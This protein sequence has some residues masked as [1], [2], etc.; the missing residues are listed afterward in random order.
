M[1]AEAFVVGE[2]ESLASAERAAGGGTE[3]IALERRCGA[4]V[5][6]VGRVEHVVAQEFKY[7]A[8]PLIAAGL[9]DDYD[10]GAGMFAEFGAVGITLDV[11]F[12]YG[13]DTKQHAAGAPGLHVVLGGSGV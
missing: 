3:L 1:L 7:C 6:E 4:L 12:A 9:G 8:M 2:E 13:V 10:L 5:E 11:E